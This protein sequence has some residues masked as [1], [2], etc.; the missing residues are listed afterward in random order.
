VKPLQQQR[1]HWAGGR[2]GDEERQEALVGLAVITL[3][4]EEAS[5]FLK[6][7]ERP[8]GRTVAKL[9]DLRRRA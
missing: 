3:D 1:A 7:L 6:A 2:H 8:D 5:R 4:E 9:A